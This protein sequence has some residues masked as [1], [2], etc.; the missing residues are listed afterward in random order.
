M[1]D[2]FAQQEKNARR[3]AKTERRYLTIG[4]PQE[5]RSL[6]SKLA[7]AAKAR[8]SPSAPSSSGKG[9]SGEASHKEK[10]SKR[11]REEKEGRLKS[12]GKS[13][14]KDSVAKSRDGHSRIHK[15][16]GGEGPSSASKGQ[17]SK[18]RP[19]VRD[20]WAEVFLPKE[21]RWVAVDLLTGSVNHPE[22][23]ESK[24]SKP[25]IYCLV[26]N[27]GKIKDVTTR[28]RALSTSLL[29]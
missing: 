12:S 2:N 21:K 26:A 16:E 15:R 1:A 20:Y 7:E 10:K 11:E 27:Q 13:S 24:C 29:L 6:S 8:L 18:I 14:K 22:E 4:C 17:K 28:Y 5:V 25:V 23:I 3:A 9:R 19:D